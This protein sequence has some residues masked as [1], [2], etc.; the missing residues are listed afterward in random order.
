MLALVANRRSSLFYTRSLGCQYSGKFSGFV[1]VALKLQRKAENPLYCI[2]LC[3][4]FTPTRKALG[5]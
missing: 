5:F 1:I 3:N 4:V 2:V